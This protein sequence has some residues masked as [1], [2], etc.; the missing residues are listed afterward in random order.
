MSTPQSILHFWF[1]ELTAKQHFV[2]DAVL[3]ETKTIIDRFGSYPHRNAILGRSFSAQEL[4][5]LSE[6]GSSF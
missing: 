3:D 6:P 4:A 2:K 5:F 1:E